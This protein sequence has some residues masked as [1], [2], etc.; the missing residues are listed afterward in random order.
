MTD[1]PVSTRVV[2]RQVE[3]GSSVDCAHCDRPI[4]F[5]ARSKP[6]QV[7]ANVYEANTWKRVEHFHEE[8]YEALGKPYGGAVLPDWRQ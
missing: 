1:G 3:P 2:L 5:S 7:I 8:C 4:K 6:R